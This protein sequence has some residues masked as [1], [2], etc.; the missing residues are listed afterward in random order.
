MTTRKIIVVACI[1][2][3]SLYCAEVRKVLFGT[4]SWMRMRSASMPPTMKKKRAESAVEEADPLVVD[5]RQPA[6][7]ARLR[8]RAPE[9]EGLRRVVALSRGNRTWPVLPWC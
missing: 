2:N 7:E 5:R 4:D 8:R 3:I 6:H 9:D 1:V